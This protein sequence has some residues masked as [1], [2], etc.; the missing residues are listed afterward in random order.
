[1]PSPVIIVNTAHNGRV[2]EASRTL[3]PGESCL[4]Y[5]PTT[6]PAAVAV[7]AVGSTAQ[8]GYSLSPVAAIE[9]G[10]GRFLPAA[11]GVDGLVV[12]GND[13]TDIPAP[14]NAVQVMNFG[15][16]QVTVELLQ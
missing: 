13:A 3:E 10:L 4:I 16:M 15:A 14:A 1:M 7:H 2:Y 8:V 12:D 9:A 6:G 11:L 5:L